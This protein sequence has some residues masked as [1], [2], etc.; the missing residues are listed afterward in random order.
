VFQRLHTDEEYEGSGVG[1]ALVDRIMK[2]HGGKVE[3]VSE[4]N[5]GTEIRL[6]F[7]G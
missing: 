6:Y 2:R 3:A 5:K 4:V 1:L 7:P